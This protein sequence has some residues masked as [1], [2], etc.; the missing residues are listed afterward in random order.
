MQQFHDIDRR[1]T[2]RR[3]VDADGTL[4]FA[5]GL[6]VINLGPRG[7]ETETSDRLMVGA[8]Y[9]LQIR[10][11]EQEHDVRGTVV[12]SRL[13]RTVLTRAGD[14][15]PVYRSGIEAASASIPTLERLVE[16][17]PRRTELA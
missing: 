5:S 6:K 11:R 8:D 4:S 3:Q 9:D 1:R 16:Q 15:T 12:W 13:D 14:I 17:A 2:D 10:W 7:L